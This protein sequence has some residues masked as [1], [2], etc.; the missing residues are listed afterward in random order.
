[1]Q[2]TLERRITRARQPQHHKQTAPGGVFYTERYHDDEIPT[3]LSEEEQQSLANLI[4]KKCRQRTKDNIEFALD[5]PLSLWR[6]Y[7][8]Y[9]RV[10]FENGEA[11]YVAGQSYPDEIRT[12]REYILGK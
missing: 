6:N 2:D 3:Y 8:I 10:M 4:G 12:V 11:H 7:G 1:M 9:G 5:I